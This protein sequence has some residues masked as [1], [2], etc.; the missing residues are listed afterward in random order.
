MGS[1]ASLGLN[2]TDELE[3]REKNRPPS[4]QSRNAWLTDEDAFGS[5][6]GGD[7]IDFSPRAPPSAAVDLPTETPSA[8]QGE[9]LAH[10]KRVT[11]DARAPG[12]KNAPVGCWTRFK[13]IVRG[14]TSRIF[15]CIFHFLMRA[16]RLRALSNVSLRAFL[17]CPLGALLWTKRGD[18]SQ[19][20]GFVKQKELHQSLGI[21]TSYA[22][23]AEIQVN[24]LDG[25]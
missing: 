24:L 10:Q 17:S 22:K 12:T 9:P 7:D 18:A 20:S 16:I 1:Q 11:A 6:Q 23:E 19:N 4:S 21:I 5:G 2:M 8:M 13:R 15:K 14:T 25:N 3:M